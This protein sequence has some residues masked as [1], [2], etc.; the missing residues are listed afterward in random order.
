MSLRIRAAVLAIASAGV[1]WPGL[2]TIGAAGTP[3]DLPSPTPHQLTLAVHQWDPSGSVRS[4]E[5]VETDDGATTITLSTDILFPSQS[6]DLPDS[7]APRIVELLGSVPD[8]ASLQVR[9]HTDSLVGPIPNDELSENRAVAVA[10]AIVAERPDLEL[11][12]AGLG[13][14]DPAVQEDPG[15]PATYAANRRVEIIHAG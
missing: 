7:A 13:A 10:E 5:S 3:E 12:V 14:T 2:G 15:D 8:G 4:F 11:D 9:G 6:Y 1:L